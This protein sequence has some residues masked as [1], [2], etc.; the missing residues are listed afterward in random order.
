MKIS[1]IKRFYIF[2][3]LLLA[4]RTFVDFWCRKKISVNN[5][6]I[7]DTTDKKSDALFIGNEI[8]LTD[9]D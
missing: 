6:G 2:E 9:K 4:T 1:L 5:S 8:V 7:I 3:L